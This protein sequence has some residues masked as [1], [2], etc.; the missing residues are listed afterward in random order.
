VDTEFPGVVVKPIGTF[1]NTAE[2]N[3]HTLRSNVDLLKIIQLGFTFSD[4]KGNLC[5]GICT[6]Q[7]NFKFNTSTDMYAQ[8]SIDLLVKS[9]L[10][11]DRLNRYGINLNTFGE[12]LMIS[13]W[14]NVFIYI[15]F[16]EM[17]ESQR[18]CFEPN[19]TNPFN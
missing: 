2:Y 1:K 18:F 15:Y 17:F 19:E 3:Y 4:E 5:P 11:F 7:F 9:G 6:W 8:S 10:D 12:L 14:L 13:G 16:F